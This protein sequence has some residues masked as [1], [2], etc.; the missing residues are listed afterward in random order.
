[1]RFENRAS[2]SFDQMRYV[3][4]VHIKLLWPKQQKACVALLSNEKGNERNAKVAG[5]KIPQENWRSG[6]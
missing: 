4:T 2:I 3:H 1:M 6:L 5:S